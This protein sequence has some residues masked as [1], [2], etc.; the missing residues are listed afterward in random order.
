MGQQP[1]GAL[2]PAPVVPLF[3]ARESGIEDD[4]P[5]TIHTRPP[6]PREEQRKSVPAL[7]GHPVWTL[8]GGNNSGKTHAARL[9][10]GNAIDQGRS[11]LLAALDPQQ[12]SLAGFFADVH[13]PPVGA[14]PPQV[15]TWLAGLIDY[16][17]QNR[18]RALLDMGGGDTSLAALVSAMPDITDV[19]EAA[20]VPIVA[21]YL[22]G[23][24]IEDLSLL[25]NF[26]AA[27]FQPRHTVLIL[28]DARVDMSLDPDTAFAAIRRRPEFRAAI[29]RGTVELRLPR[30]DQGV[31]LEIER[32]RLP[33]S[34]AAT[35]KVPDGSKVTPISGIFDRSKVLNH[36]KACQDAFAPIQGWLL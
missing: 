20:G 4:T 28:N 3:G 7:D 16:I 31:A 32:K 1:K 8:I 27:G 19:M 11:F 36:L 24:R 10:V 12:R 6:S 18:P 23:P 26:E 17:L 29:A 34:Y 33:F 13:Q 22:L 5:L 9:L 14:T 35:N 15:E 25:A 2:S 21:A 30:L